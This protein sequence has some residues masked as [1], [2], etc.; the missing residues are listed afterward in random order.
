MSAPPPQYEKPPPY[1]PYY[2]REF[3]RPKRIAVHPDNPLSSCVSCYMKRSQQPATTGLPTTGP[4]AIPSAGTTT[5]LWLA[6]SAAPA[7]GDGVPESASAAVPRLRVDDPGAT[8]AGS[9]VCR[10]V[11]CV[12]PRDPGR[13]VHGVRDSDG[14]L[15]LPAG[16]PLLPR[17]EGETLFPL[18]SHV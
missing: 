1:S 5:A 12:S 6:V 18:R 17:H 2:D 11:S 10:R 15:L 14:H 7:T 3:V 9:G 16:H 13:L 8:A 4:T